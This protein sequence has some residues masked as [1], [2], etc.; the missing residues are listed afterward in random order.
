MAKDSTSFING[1]VSFEYG[2]GHSV[3]LDAF[4]T[5]VLTNF[6]KLMLKMAGSIPAVES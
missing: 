3:M 4:S 1:D 2:G 5:I 6:P